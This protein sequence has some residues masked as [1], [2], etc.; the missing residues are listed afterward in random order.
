MGNIYDDKLRYDNFQS[1]QDN[2]ENS[3]QAS[4]SNYSNE[5]FQSKLSYIQNKT[6][7]SELMFSTIPAGLGKAVETYSRIKDVYQKSQNVLGKADELV[8]NIKGKAGE[9]VDTVQGKA[10]ELLNKAQGMAGDLVDNVQDK[11]SSIVDM[12]QGLIDRVNAYHDANPDIPE[13]G[14]QISLDIMKNLDESQLPLMNKAFD[15]VPMNEAMT[16]SSALELQSNLS[17]TVQTATFGNVEDY[18]S[19]LGK[20]AVLPN[21]EN[22]VKNA[23]SKPLQD[24]TDEATN[25]VAGVSDTVKSAV[26][27]ASDLLAEGSSALAEASVP[28]VGDVLAL[29]SLI[30]GGYEGIKDLINKPKAPP[31]PAINLMP[32]GVIQAGI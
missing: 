23:I 28:I 21:P 1:M 30:F 14:R 32:T 6:I 26:S 18:S 31:T 7:G 4:A 15:G 17:K 29:G 9:L 3:I 25:A 8:D 11:L 22:M 12:R 16:P 24:I 2:I 13:A 5:L 20:V 10:G 27:G 19:A